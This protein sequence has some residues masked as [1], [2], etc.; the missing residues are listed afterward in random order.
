MEPTG[1]IALV[2][3]ACVLDW[4]LGDPVYRLH[5]I[6]LIGAWSLRAERLLF[7][8]GWSGRGGGILH[9]ALVVGVALA[10]W[11]GV[12]F[13]LGWMH[14][15][16]AWVWDVYIAYSL[17]CMRD[18]LLHGE[19]V[20]A[21]LDDLPKARAQVGMLVARDTDRLDAGGVVRATIESLS[22]N[23]TDGV[24]TPLW[25]LCLFGL[26]G[27]ILV[28]AVS[29]LDSMVGYKNARYARFGWAA[30]RS[31]DVIHWIPARLSVPLIA[32]AAIPLRLHPLL[33]LRAAWDDHAMLPSPN[34]GWSEAA[35]AGALRVRLIG[36]IY[37]EGVLVT[38]CYMG[39][40]DWPADLDGG[41]LR[42]ALRLI[43]LAGV[44]AL[45]AGLGLAIGVG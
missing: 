45:V 2:L 11:L 32:L 33:A 9:W 10:G 31:D 17:L 18:L 5:P 7:R 41:H 19:R 35:C 26:P 25:A 13:A 37:S 14:P 1:H 39:H 12:R 4:L 34:S 22:E 20:L 30:A 21:A 40:P 16:M 42:R 38:Q 36:P 8:R 27:L 24:L 23:L 43:G 28:K 6:R 15:W 44:L 3:V 29:N